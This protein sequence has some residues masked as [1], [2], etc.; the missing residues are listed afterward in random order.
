MVE[1]AKRQ[2]FRPEVWATVPDADVVGMMVARYFEWDGY[3]VMQ[4][5]YAALEDAN[6]HRENEK[7]VEMFPYMFPNQHV[8]Q[9]H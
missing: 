3:K 5:T 4:T 7:I 6:F 8:P 9:V 2:M 1:K